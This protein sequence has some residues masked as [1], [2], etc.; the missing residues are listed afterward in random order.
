MPKRTVMSYYY[1][2]DDV[3]FTRKMRVSIVSCGLMACLDHYYM[4]ARSVIQ[5]NELYYNT[6]EVVCFLHMNV[7][8]S[9][10]SYLMNFIVEVG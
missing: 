8:W 3:N 1:D 6:H 2:D 10:Y 7:S 4:I 9:T 5:C